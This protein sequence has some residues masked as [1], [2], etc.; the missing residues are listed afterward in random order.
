VG[1]VAL[2]LSIG[3]GE[4]RYLSR[5][6]I[7][8]AIWPETQSG[9]L[10]MYWLVERFMRPL[11]WG[12]HLTCILA[13]LGSRRIRWAGIDYLIRSPQNVSVLGRDPPTR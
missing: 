11:W 6:R 1:V 2:A 7:V 12:F 3:L 5:R 13:A 10:K 9:D 4:L 8:D